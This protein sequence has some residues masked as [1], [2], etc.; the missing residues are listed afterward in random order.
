MS[1]LKLMLRLFFFNHILH[2]SQIRL[3]PAYSPMVKG[4][5]TGFNDLSAELR[6]TIYELSGCLKITG[7]NMILFDGITYVLP[8]QHAF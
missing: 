6:N 7:R 1:L 5:T 2:T 4:H 8:L 3:L